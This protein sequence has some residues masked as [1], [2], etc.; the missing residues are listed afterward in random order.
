M[1]ETSFPSRRFTENISSFCE[2]RTVWER[3][4]DPTQKPAEPPEHEP[5]QPETVKPAIEARRPVDTE[6]EPVK[7]TSDYHCG[8]FGFYPDALQKYRTSRCA[9]LILCFTSFTRSFSMN[10]VMMVVLPTLERRYQIK[11]YESGMILSSND[12]ASCLAML[13]V[14]FLATQRHKPRF[15]AYGIATMGIGN[16]VVTMVHFLSPPY[17]LSVSVSSICPEVV[18]SRCSEGGSIRYFRFLLMAGQLL[19]GI[20]ATPINTVTIAY[21]DENLPKKKSSFYI[22]RQPLLYSQ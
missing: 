17:P 7:P 16:L 15:I 1:D 12:V 10:G 4:N 18:S 9:L 8:C 3:T 19:S 2:D 14:S 11:S 20:G 21:L 6:T 13:P 22:G 5:G